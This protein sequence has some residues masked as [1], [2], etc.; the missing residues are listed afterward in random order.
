MSIRTFVMFFCSAAILIPL[1]AGVA[2]WISQAHAATPADRADC[3]RD[4]G[5][6]VMSPDGSVVCISQASVIWEAARR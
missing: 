1:C 3:R 4:R 6:P 5:V 2:A